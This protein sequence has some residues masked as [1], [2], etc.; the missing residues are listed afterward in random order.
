MK[1][2]RS[3]ISKSRNRGQARCRWT[4]PQSQDPGAPGSLESDGSG[5]WLPVVLISILAGGIGAVAA[6]L[7]GQSILIALGLYSG[8]GILAIFLM[9]TAVFLSDTSRQQSVDQ[10][11]CQTLYPKD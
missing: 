2:A 7:S 5:T 4:Q 10:I 1:H 6:L 9:A 3:A 8:T 11:G